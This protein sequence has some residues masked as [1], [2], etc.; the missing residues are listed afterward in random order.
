MW[1][2]LLQG[3]IPMSHL[4]RVFF[5]LPAAFCVLVSIPDRIDA[6]PQLGG[7][8]TRTINGSVVLQGTTVGSVRVMIESSSGSFHRT[9]YTDGASS[10]GISGVPV[11]QYT[12]TLEAEGYQLQQESVDVPP[13]SGILLVQFTMRPALRVANPASKESSVSVTTLHIPPDAQ[14]E[15]AAGQP[16]MQRQHWKEAR[17]HFEKALKKHAEF[18]QA[19]RGLG[20][21]ELRE[22]HLEQALQLLSRAVGLDPSYAEGQLLLSHVLN[23][24]G[25]H[26][27]ALDAARKVVSLRPDVWQAQYE[28]G[29]A[30]LSLGQD[31]IALE[32]SER[33]MSAAGPNIAEARLLRAGVFLKRLKY[34]EA[35]SE[36]LAFLQ[37]APNHEFAPLAKKTLAEVE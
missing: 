30:A 5:F 34:K 36:L 32:A 25:K 35:K 6:S 31:E 19:L 18:P 24:L 20:L 12:F 27:E 8:G 23:I 9:V 14:I 33:I 10:F 16:D 17:G 1:Y 29:V 15:F 22:Q 2:P 13:G 3:V 11:G 7:G 26:T 28:L 4:F 21:L 37:L